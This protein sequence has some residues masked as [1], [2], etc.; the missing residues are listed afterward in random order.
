MIFCHN[1]NI[2]K[3]FFVPQSAMC[4][5][6]AAAIFQYKSHSHYSN[7]P[8]PTANISHFK[9]AT[10]LINPVWKSIK[11]QRVARLPFSKNLIQTH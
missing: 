6:P 11:Y 9:I 10:F 3:I 8:P 4:V 7:N 5:K 2:G 1:K